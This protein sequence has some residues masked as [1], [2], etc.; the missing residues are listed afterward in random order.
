MLAGLLIALALQDPAPQEGLVLDSHGAPVPGAAVLLLDRWH[1]EPFP[2]Y[3]VPGTLEQTPA[4]QRVGT[5]DHRGHLLRP[6]A[7]TIGAR[8]APALVV[9]SEAGLGCVPL[10]TGEPVDISLTPPRAL[11]VELLDGGRP[12]AGSRLRLSPEHCAQGLA[13]VLNPEAWEDPGVRAL[14]ERLAF[15]TTDG[16]GVASLPY[17]PQCASFTGWTLL[18]GPH[19]IPVDL[20]SDAPSLR[21]DLADQRTVTLLGRVVDERGR[22]IE[23]ATINVH[24]VR[25]PQLDSPHLARATSDVDGTYRLDGV[26]LDDGEVLVDARH[27][28]FGTAHERARQYRDEAEFEWDLQL[29]RRAP[30]KGRLVQLDGG[31]VPGVTVL[32]RRPQQARP[33]ARART[34]AAGE[35]AFESRMSGPYQLSVEAGSDQRLFKLPVSWAMAGDLD[36]TLRACVMSKQTSDVHVRFTEQGSEE[37]LD[38][39][40]VWLVPRGFQGSPAFR[41]FSRQ[42]VTANGEV[43]FKGVFGGDWVVIAGGEALHPVHVPVRVGPGPANVRIEMRFPITAPLRGRVLFPPGTTP[44]KSWVRATW[45]PGP[46]ELGVQHYGW[47]ELS[48][49]GRFNMGRIYEGRIDVQLSA[50]GWQARKTI[51]LGPIGQ[52]DLEL[53]AEPS[54]E[55]ELVPDDWPDPGR[56]ILELA[57]EGEPWRPQT[58]LLVPNNAERELFTAKVP[59]GDWRWRVRIQRSVSFRF[60]RE[61]VVDLPGGR[62]SLRAGVRTPVTVPVGLPDYP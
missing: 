39:A 53:R 16:N 57:G 22:S 36:V 59:P 7:E 14:I 33:S 19:A 58:E 42:A 18:V 5:T 46:L 45:K 1:M 29:F 60:R 50:A 62:V 55:L 48:A 12:V 28:D 21:V 54:A 10:L 24:W 6:S 34:N 3:R 27:P 2:Q 20:T 47:V 49:D 9:L 25:F 61:I 15:A 32:A 31:P 8:W 41:G 26:S 23:G 56:Y 52:T 43:I 11:R 37:A 40:Y 38:P 13:A 44:P 35:F 51:E 30:I 17:L 4:H